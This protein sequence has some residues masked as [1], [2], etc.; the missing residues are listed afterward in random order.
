MSTSYKGDAD[1]LKRK[2]FESIIESKMIK[3]YL[4][5]V[6]AFRLT[7]SSEIYIYIIYIIKSFMFIY[8]YLYA[9][10]LLRGKNATQ[11]HHLKKYSI[12]KQINKKGHFE[13]SPA[14]IVNCCNEAS[15]LHFFFY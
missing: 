1:F 9:N 13:R 12:R 14:I 2:S 15:V 10:M 7:P 11:K 6:K 8:I 4:F 3:I 5:K